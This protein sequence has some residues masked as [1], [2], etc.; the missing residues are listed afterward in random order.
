[1]GPEK[2]SLKT[3]VWSLPSLGTGKRKGALLPSCV[4]VGL[5]YHSQMSKNGC[6]KKNKQN[7]SSQFSEIQYI[8]GGMAIDIFSLFCQLEFQD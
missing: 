7:L 3:E 5:G 2:G 6:V 1:M 8:L 4:N